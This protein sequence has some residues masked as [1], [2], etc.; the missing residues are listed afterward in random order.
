M[1]PPPVLFYNP[2]IV[3][4]IIR[5]LLILVFSSTA[6]GQSEKPEPD[7]WKGLRLDESTAE[8]V[9]QK[10]G[11]PKSDKIDKVA[12]P[13]VGKLLTKE[14]KEKKWRVI[15]Y[16]QIENAKDALFV[17][18]TGNRLLIIHF[19]PAAALSPQAL[20]NAYQLPFKPVF[21]GIDQAMSPG[22][23]SRDGNGSVY[24]KS[25]P[26]VYFIVAAADKSFVV[27]GIGNSSFGA[28]FK[29]SI[30]LPDSGTTYPGKVYAVE[31]ISRTLENKDNV[32]VLK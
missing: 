13:A 11:K 27:A 1:L 9:L 20:V 2:R 14:L 15:H 30:G 22:D 4:N 28:V 3:K 29:K 6:F 31:L 23:F 8:Q 7:K 10:F 18:G 21:S 26:T 19:E 16:E 32:D 17:F 25:Y 24:A 5:L 12:L